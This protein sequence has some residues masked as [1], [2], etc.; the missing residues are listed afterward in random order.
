[1]A[2]DAL[3]KVR[4]G[5]RWADADVVYDP[6][7]EPQLRDSVDLIVR[8]W[9]EPRGRFLEAGCGPAANA[10]NLARLGAEVVGV[11]LAPEAVQMARDAFARHGMNGEF[12]VGDVRNLPFPDDSFD[13]VYAGGVV[14]H[15]RES[16]QAVAEMARVL[17]PGGRV[18]FTVPA[19][20]LSYPYLFLRGNVPAVR[21]V[22]EAASFVQFRLLHGALAGFGYE[23]SFRR[24]DVSRVMIDAQLDTFEVGRFDTYV[25]LVSVPRRLRGLARRLA[26]TDLFAPM[27]YGVGTKSP[28]TQGAG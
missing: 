13:F 22:E 18:L 20:N 4:W 1:M 6:A 5:Q 2:Y 16:A 9:P 28:L 24:R 11:D 3:T 19:L 27:Y 14:E 7:S 21:F 10:L 17:R 12:V 8:F 26:R 25:P 23:R 15:F